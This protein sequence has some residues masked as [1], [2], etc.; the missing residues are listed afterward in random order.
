M[1]ETTTAPCF[2][3]K[4]TSHSEE[5]SR[6]NRKGSSLYA[7]DNILCSV[8]DNITINS[9]RRHVDD[10]HRIAIAARIDKL[11]L[12]GSSQLLRVLSRV[13]HVVTIVA[14]SDRH[15]WV[16]G[17]WQARA[18]RKGH[19]MMCCAKS[20]GVGPKRSCSSWFCGDRCASSMVVTRLK[21]SSDENDA[22]GVC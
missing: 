6:N 12:P 11:L 1:D 3:S 15:G 17:H 8:N 19:K 10:L 20:L 7:E 21:R 22:D 9:F 18:T 5:L 4:L 16:L 13:E 2:A 14:K